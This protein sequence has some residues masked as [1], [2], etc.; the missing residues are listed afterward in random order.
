MPLLNV[1]NYL[2]IFSLAATIFILPD[3]VVYYFPGKNRW[4]ETGE[5]YTIVLIIFL[6]ITGLVMGPYAEF[7]NYILLPAGIGLA[8]WEFFRFL[9]LNNKMLNLL[10]GATFMGFMVLLFYSQWFHTP[11]YPEVIILGQGFDQLFHS[12]ISNM[13]STVGYATT[14]LDGVPYFNYHW[15][16]HIL[17]AGFKNFTGVNTIM[18]YNIVYPAIFSFV[19]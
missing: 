18:F 13:F 1:Y 15:G 5:F 4:F 10:S 6:G 3:F 14:G 8:F 16:S 12:S 17:F 19:F 2:S 11:V 9:K 7:V